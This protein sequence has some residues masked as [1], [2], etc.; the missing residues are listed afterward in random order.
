MNAV[1]RVLLASCCQARTRR[2]RPELG[3]C[4]SNCVELHAPGRLI[5]NIV[6]PALVV[7]R[8]ATF[9]GNCRMGVADWQGGAAGVVDG[10]RGREERL[11]YF[12]GEDEDG[13]L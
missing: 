11:G 4:A 2:I 7:E 8:G 9:D 12:V 6:S 10:G 3:I 5:G 13:D 1:R